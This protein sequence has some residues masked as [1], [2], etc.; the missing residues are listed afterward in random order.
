MTNLEFA[1]AL[2]AAIGGTVEVEK[3]GLA[4][5]HHVRPAGMAARLE[6]YPTSDS[7]GMRMRIR[8]EVDGAD[9]L[10]RHTKPET[11]EMTVAIDRPMDKI[12]REV[13]RR[14]LK[15][16]PPI[17]EETQAKIAAHNDE[18]AK[19]ALYKL[20]AE[21]LLPGLS[22]TPDDEG[23][24]GTMYFNKSGHGHFTGNL[25]ANGRVSFQRF[26]ISGLDRAAEFFKMMAAPA[27]EEVA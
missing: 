13:E 27:E 25:Y 11:P 21:R 24:S 26:S 5:W 8:I 18:R 4:T 10:N 2:A 22:I 14:I 3:H 9:K 6:V 17:I 15:L 20:T 1:T 12:A 23:T 7:K 16:M 19:F